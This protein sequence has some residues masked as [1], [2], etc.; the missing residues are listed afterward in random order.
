MKFINRENQVKFI[1]ETEILAKKK[2]FS[3]VIYGLRRVGKTRLILEVLKDN[4]IYLFVNK[5]KT[6]ESLLKEYEE[7]LKDKGILNEIEYLK[8]WDKFFETIFK[9]YK[10]V[11]AFDEFQNFIQ[12]DPS[13]F[14]ILQKYI[15]LNENKKGL[16]LI[17]S[18]STIGLIKKIF[19]NFKEPLYGRV[20]RKLFLKPLLFSCDLQNNYLCYSPSCNLLFFIASN[21][22]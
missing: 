17:F 14:G 6:S 7:I 1:N 5:D 21:R 10:G 8:S 9:R 19:V 15:D 3:L 20:K 11:I 2:L 18:G 13:I 4:D 22:C 16:L 12:V